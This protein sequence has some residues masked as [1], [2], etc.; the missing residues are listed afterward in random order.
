MNKKKGLGRGLDVLLKSSSDTE[1]L[2]YLSVDML[3]AGKYQPRTH[4]AQDALEEL[5]QSISN[6]G[7]IQP[8]LVRKLNH[9]QY[10][11]IAGERRFRAAKLAGLK[12][13]PAI[14]QEISDEET[15]IIALI[16]NIQRED[17]NALELAHGLQRLIQE[18]DMTHEALA[19]TIGKSRSHVT[20]VL[21][22]LALA[23]PVHHYILEGQLD[24]GHARAL[25]SLPQEQQIS[26]AK[27]IVLKGLSVRQTEKLVANLTHPATASIKRD[28]NVFM[29]QEKSLSQQLGAKVSIHPITKG[30][31]R[32]N[33][34]Y[35]DI[36]QLK[37]LL[38]YLERL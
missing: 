6:Q 16:E 18:F 30:G 10:E 17:L 12:E 14:V 20:N 32:I 3:Q 33:I 11:I 4:L 23:E 27:E 35:Q 15:A 29:A 28:D 22:L 38:I 19:K 37:S 36:E 9:S 8:I 31:G 34:E 5:V 26:G 7:V 13:I 2:Q 25:L 24:M 21:R 1:R